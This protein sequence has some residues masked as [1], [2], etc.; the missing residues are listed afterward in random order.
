[1]SVKAKSDTPRNAHLSV[2]INNCDKYTSPLKCFK[3]WDAYELTAQEQSLL[4]AKI[5]KSLNNVT[6]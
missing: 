1:M 6:R 5:T 3:D 2:A 4:I